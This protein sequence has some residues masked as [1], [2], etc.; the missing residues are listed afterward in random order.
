MT[1]HTHPS[2]SASLT[3][4][5]RA[6]TSTMVCVD[7]ISI[8][9]MT[10]ALPAQTDASLMETFGISLNTWNKLK[11]GEPIRKSVAVR[12]IERLDRI[13]LA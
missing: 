2:A 8:E 11:K 7:G 5:G 4:V 13:H 9:S 10:R 12:L 1:L 6:S 3:Y